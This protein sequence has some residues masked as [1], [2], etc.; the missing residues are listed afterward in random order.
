MLEQNLVIILDPMKIIVIALSPVTPIL[1]WRIYAQLGYS[2]DQFDARAHTHTEKCQ[3]IINFKC[4]EYRSKS[5]VI[6]LTTKFR[7]RKVLYYQMT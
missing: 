4:Q 5:M 6:V 1:S 7:K 2:R 3:C